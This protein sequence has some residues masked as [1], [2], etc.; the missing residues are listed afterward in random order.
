MK[1]K[2]G[3]NPLK[4]H[5]VQHKPLQQQKKKKIQNLYFSIHTTKCKSTPWDSL[6]YRKQCFRHTKHHAYNISF[7]HTIYSDRQ[8]LYRYFAQHLLF[9]A[10]MREIARDKNFNLINFKHITE[11]S[12][13]FLYV[14]I[15]TSLC[16]L[17]CCVVKAQFSLIFFCCVCRHGCECVLF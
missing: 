10:T 13:L 4:V 8:W 16:N 12:G 14:H 7:I 17:V 9:T 5:I 3:K 6:R 1:K 11:G 2:F 15:Y